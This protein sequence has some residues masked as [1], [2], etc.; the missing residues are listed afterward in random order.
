MAEICPPCLRTL[1]EMCHVASPE[2]R[3]QVCELE[4][5]YAATGNPAVVEQAIAL[6]PHAVFQARRAL[7]A[8]GEL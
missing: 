5:T 4:A 3:T 1:R 2:L 6:A 7:K 8:R